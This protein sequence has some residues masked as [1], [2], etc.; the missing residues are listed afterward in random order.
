[1]QWISPINGNF[2]FDHGPK[3]EEPERDGSR[4]QRS[5]P[6]W[7]DEYVTDRMEYSCYLSKISSSSLTMYSDRFISASS[8][9][10]C[11]ALRDLV[12]LDDLRGLHFDLCL[13][14][15]QFF[16]DIGKMNGILWNYS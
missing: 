3:G 4:R 5:R 2:H 8:L 14:L 7:I 13:K 16:I 9:A 6:V 12:V 10:R 15:V 1:M 11:F